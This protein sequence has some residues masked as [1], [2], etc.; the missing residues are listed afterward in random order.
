MGGCPV[1]NVPGRTFPVNAYF[2]EDAVELS[3]YR[4]DIGS[5]SPYVQR[6]Q[7]QCYHWQHRYTYLLS[8]REQAFCS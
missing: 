3:G 7:S 8:I 1:L 5:D 6:Y 2:L 4:L